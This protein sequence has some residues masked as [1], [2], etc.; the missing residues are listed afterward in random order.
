MSQRL[1]EVHRVIMEAM[2]LRVQKS[3]RNKRLKD[4]I[5]IGVFMSLELHQQIYNWVLI[6]MSVCG[7]LCFIAL[8]FVKAGYGKFLDKSWGLAFNNKVAWFF[9]EVPT[10]I[11][12]LIMI[13]L[14]PR[15]DSMIRLIIVAFYIGHYVQRTLVFPFLMKGKSKMPALIVFMGAFFNTVNAFLIASWIFYLSPADYYS[16]GWLYDIRFMLG[17]IVFALG[18]WI[19]LTSDAY[20]RSL[21]KNGDSKHYFP[22]NG[23]YKYVTSANYLGEIIE[24]TGF[25]FLSWSLPGVFFVFWTIA[26]LVPRAHAINKSY[27]EKFPEEFAKTKPK[28]IFPF[29]Y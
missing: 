26:N 22:Q 12:M 20:I 17:V 14:S 24:W 25:A 6:S 9:M 21:R 23:V 8:Y 16:T 3:L 13:T 15:K 28:R 1:L 5:A 18:M 19:N 27:R 7:L 2:M 10:L 4:F 29:V 11:V